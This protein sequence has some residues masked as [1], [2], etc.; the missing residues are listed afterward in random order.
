MA[1]QSSLPVLQRDLGLDAATRFSP[2]I[3]NVYGRLV[4]SGLL[5][6]SVT[7]LFVNEVST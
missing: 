2:Y 1:K 3:D 7:D 5:S 6:G 4:S